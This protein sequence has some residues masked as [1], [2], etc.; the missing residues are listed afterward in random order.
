LAKFGRELGFG[1]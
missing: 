1:R